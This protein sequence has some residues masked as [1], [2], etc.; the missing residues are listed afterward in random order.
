[1][2]GRHTSGRPCR[3]LSSSGKPLRR[4]QEQDGIGFASERNHLGHRMTGV[5]T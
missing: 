3:V 5:L 2:N 1:M 4:F